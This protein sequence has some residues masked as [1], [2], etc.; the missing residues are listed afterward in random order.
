MKGY[1]EPKSRV[2]LILAARN[3]ADRDV[4]SKSDPMCVVYRVDNNVAREV[5]RTETIKDNLS[6]KWGTK[7][8]LDY[9]FERR[10][11]LLFKIYDIDSPT[12]ELTHHDF[13][14]EC[15]TD[16]ADILAAPH[17]YLTISLSGWSGA[18]GH[19]IVFAEEVT[20]VQNDFFIFKIQ[21]IDLHKKFHF[22][23][24]DTYLEFLRHLP[25]GSRHLVLRTAV[26]NNSCFPTYSQVD[27]QIRQLCGNE[28]TNEF[29]IQC[30]RVGSNG[31]M[32]VGEVTTTFDK[33]KSSGSTPLPI[34]NP[35]K[36]RR[37]SYKDSGALRF[38]EARHEKAHSFVEFIRG[39]LQ[40]DFAVCIDF[41]A[42]NG[43]VHSQQSLH[44]I[45]PQNQNQYELAIGAVLEICQ[46]Y[47]HTKQFEVMGFGAKIPPSNTVSHLFPLDLETRQRVING[48]ES[49]LQMYR[50]A[51]FSIQFYGPT[52]FSPSVKEFAYKASLLAKE[53]NRYQMLLIITDGEITDMLK[54]VDA[55]VDASDKPLS[56]IIVGV[57]NASFDKMDDLDS[58][59]AMLSASNGRKA[60]RDIVQFVPFRDFFP[61]SGMPRSLLEADQI[62]RRLAEAV[63]EEV[64]E[65]VTSYMRM[66]KISPDPPRFQLPPGDDLLD[67]IPPL[68]TSRPVDSML[69]TSQPPVNPAYQQVLLA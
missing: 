61:P 31:N 58:D 53:K 64:P 3:L 57:G 46:H 22:I 9:Y 48:V 40:L 15:S 55:I 36:I 32:L 18:R 16:L 52:N 25:D 2:E 19:M 6:P 38:L 49:V 45:D 1:N 4:M 20:Q 26:V 51:L 21:A 56:I 23:Q 8:K 62:K 65:Q 34:L 60:L 41:T 42:S 28:L 17:G 14:G 35:R 5:A 29:T 39:G 43:S 33:I 24:P 67:L 69:D 68:N 44:Y 59:Q 27:L 30:F 63:L 10:Q 47:N 11:T 54:T 12:A 66:M 50:K 7:I 37:S 13:L